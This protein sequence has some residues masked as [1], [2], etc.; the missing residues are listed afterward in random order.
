MSKNQT[1]TMVEIKPKEGR[2]LATA[3]RVE[4]FQ[5]RWCVSCSPEEI[6]EVLIASDDGDGDFFPLW[7]WKVFG[8]CERG[9][10]AFTILE[11]PESADRAT[12]LVSIREPEPTP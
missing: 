5:E 6:A 10:E 11:L 7:G 1:T 9:G 2:R 4:I 3:R 8:S 12:V